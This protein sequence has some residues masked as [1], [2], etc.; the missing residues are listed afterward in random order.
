M[1][2]FNTL[3]KQILERFITKCLNRVGSDKQVRLIFAKKNDEL[4]R[5]FNIAQD[6]YNSKYNMYINLKMFEIFDNN[7]FLACVAHELGH[8]FHNRFNVPHHKREYIADRMAVR[9]GTNPRDL[10][11]S[12]IILSRDYRPMVSCHSETHPSIK[13]RAEALNISSETI[14]RLVKL[15]YSIHM[16]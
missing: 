15:D 6:A 16:R 10:I 13:Q 12:L 3:T 5:S 4:Y 7:Q 14:D 1:R 11:D 8:L 9:F 2:V